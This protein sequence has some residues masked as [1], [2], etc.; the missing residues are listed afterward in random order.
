MN[1]W[2][3][4]VSTGQSNMRW[5]FYQ[6]VLWVLFVCYLKLMHVPA[7]NA[8]LDLEEEIALTNV[9]RQFQFPDWQGDPCVNVTWIKCSAGSPSSNQR[10]ETLDLR[11]MNLS[12]TIPRKLGTFSGLKY[13][14]LYQNQLTGVIPEEISNLSQLQILALSENRLEGPILNLSNLTK[15]TELWLSDNNLNG[16]IPGELSN[17]SQLQKLA[18]SG[19]QLSGPVPDLS[20]MK[21]LAELHLHSNKL[22]GDIP[23]GLGNLTQLQYLDLHRNQLTGDIPKEL[24]KLSYVTVLSLSENK[25]SGP[26]PDLSNMTSLTDL[27]LKANN[28]VGDIPKGLGKLSTLEILSL[29]YNNLTGVIPKELGALSQLKSMYLHFN[30]LTGEIPKEFRSLTQLQDLYL[31]YNKLSG[32]IP[33]LS[34]LTSLLH[35]DLQNNQLNG[36]V[37]ETIAALPRLQT[38]FL[39][40]NDFTGISESITTMKGLNLTYDKSVN[41]IDGSETSPSLTGSIISEVKSNA[42]STG[43]I[44]GGTIG[45]LGFLLIVIFLFWIRRK[46][47]RYYDQIIK[48]DM[49]KSVQAFTLKQIKLITERNQNFIAK[50][51]FG[52]VYR[53]KL[54]DGREVA[55]KVRATDSKQGDREFLNEVRLLSRLHH[56]NL[57]PLVGY[58]WEAKQQIL[59]YEYMPQGTLHD[60]LYQTESSKRKTMKWKTRLDIAVNCARGLEYLHK[61]CK[62]PVIHRDM[63]TSNIL[64]TDKLQAKLG[65][66]GISKQTFEPDSEEANIMTGIS[67]EIKGTR[68]YLDPE[69][70]ERQRLTTKSDVYSFG[71]VLLEIITGRKPLFQ[72]FP[73]GT[74]SNLRDWAREAVENDHL[75]SI[76]DPALNGDYNMEGMLLVVN[77]ALSCVLSRGAERPEMGDIVH[78][79]IQVVQ[80]E[81]SAHHGEECTDGVTEGSMFSS[82]QQDISSGSFLSTGPDVCKHVSWDTDP[83]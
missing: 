69:Y 83:R 1:V 16:S 4:S 50:G 12:G 19:N 37:P 78:T 5:G 10:V 74:A 2:S 75:E 70:Y 34:N 73:T 36:T 81:E 71:I 9:S 64:L 20:Q 40:N 67:T 58:C 39:E 77:L 11:Q 49:P 54:V 47:M 27:W 31:S 8:V 55:V 57:V 41:I 63:K 22:T 62:P 21:N 43:A 60:H 66:L 38:L 80:M 68:G 28:L 72:R 30:E 6:L 25:F 14:F 65:D 44:V 61:D 15:L 48:E 79:L 45:G 82:D 24:N 42:R 32:S 7:A 59:V 18:L 13:L 3:A 53:G 52:N 29:D 23:K 33:D 35:I 51:G 17:L 76:V 26:I 56:R 46:R